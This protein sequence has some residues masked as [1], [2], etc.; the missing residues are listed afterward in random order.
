M[1]R[2]ASYL[3]T[4]HNLAFNKRAI[5]AAEKNH[6]NVVSSIKKVLDK[7]EVKEAKRMRGMT[8]EMAKT[9]LA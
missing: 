1:N 2:G 7:H 6:E 5:Q 3:V 9:A 4:P 8:E